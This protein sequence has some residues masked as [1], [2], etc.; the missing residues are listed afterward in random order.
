VS[1]PIEKTGNVQN[2]VSTDTTP[3]M[4]GRKK[5]VS[6]DEIAQRI[7]DY[8]EKHPDAGDT[9]EGTATWWVMQQ[10]VYES[11]ELVRRSLERLKADGLIQECRNLDGRIIYVACPCPRPRE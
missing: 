4:K 11:V 6:D 2:E 5:I 9:L 8:L 10:Q 3:P 7:L 1:D